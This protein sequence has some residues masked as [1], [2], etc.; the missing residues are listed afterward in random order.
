MLAVRRLASS[1]FIAVVTASAL[2]TTVT[3]EE[4]DKTL[5]ERIAKEKEDRKACKKL[6]CDIAQKHLPDGADVACSVV[7]TWLPDD[8]KKNVLMGRL[9]WPYGAAQCKADIKMPRKMLSEVLS[10]GEHEAKLDKHALSCSLDQKDGKA[11]FT[12][13][14]SVA[15]VVKFKD[16]KAVK[17]ILNWSDISGSAVATGAVWSVA[18]L[19]NNLGVLEGAAANAVDQFFGPHCEEV[20]E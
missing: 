16:G 10:P 19:D 6:I 3:A 14:F 13:S 4:V 12:I 11:A 15:P 18:T 8:L 9:D 20:K 5:L 17:V 2:S 1:L 7:K